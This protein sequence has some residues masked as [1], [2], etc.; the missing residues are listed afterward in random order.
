MTQT[1]P[2]GPSTVDELLLVSQVRRW[3]ATGEARR[4]REM[5]RVTVGEVASAIRGNP[6]TITKWEA[7]QAAPSSHIALAYGKALE[8]LR[9]MAGEAL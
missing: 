8:A 3:C 9:S 7:G 5:A 4:I 1:K 2:R 6:N